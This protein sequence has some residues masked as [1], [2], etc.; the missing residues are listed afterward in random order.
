MVSSVPTGCYAVGKS[1]MA[2]C[3]DL[4]I[5]SI[6]VRNTGTINR[7]AS[8]MAGSSHPLSTA[9]EEHSS[10]THIQTHTHRAIQ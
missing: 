4:L 2:R 5:W 9:S 8:G 7:E 6:T 1:M 3:S 10:H